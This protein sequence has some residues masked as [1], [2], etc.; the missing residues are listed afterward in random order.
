MEQGPNLTQSFGSVDL[1]L[2][3]LVK[4]VHVAPVVGSEFGRVKGPVVHVQLGKKGTLGNRMS[5]L[6]HRDMNQVS[7]TYTTWWLSDIRFLSFLVF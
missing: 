6:N 4:R 5:K 2:T 1:D 7:Y 3:R